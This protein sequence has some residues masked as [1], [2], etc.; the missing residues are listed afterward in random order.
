MCIHTSDMDDDFFSIEK[1][2]K[3]HFIVQQS[4]RF[5]LKCLQALYRI[6]LQSISRIE[7]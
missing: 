6:K 3:G 1:V 7:A 4:D 5:S 2:T